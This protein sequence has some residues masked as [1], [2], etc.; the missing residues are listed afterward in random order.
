MTS[1]PTSVNFAEPIPSLP[2]GTSTINVTSR[3][4]NGS[5]FTAGS[6][7]QFDLVKRGFLIP[8]SLSIRYKA[9]VTSSATASE[10]MFSLHF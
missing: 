5:S 8:D 6:I 7:I 4:T 3:P 2:D 9:T 1:L 10:M